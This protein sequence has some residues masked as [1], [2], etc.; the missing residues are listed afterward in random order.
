MNELI[1]LTYEEFGKLRFRDFFP[2]RAGK[3][4]YYFDDSGGM[5]CSVGI[6]DFEGYGPSA[7]FMSKRGQTCMIDVAFYNGCPEAEAHALLELLGLAIRKGMSD[8]Q[9]KGILGKPHKE[10]HPGWPRFIVGNE[11]QY[12]VDCFIDKNSGLAQIA[13]SRKDLAD[14]QETLETRSNQ[15]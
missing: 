3:L 13:I 15:L 9:L 11:C 5:E 12:Y 1:N 4:S 10:D 2:K 7:G 8:A 6:A 14:K